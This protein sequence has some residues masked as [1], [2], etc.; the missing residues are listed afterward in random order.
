MRTKR[1]MIEDLGIASRDD[2]DALGTI[3]WPAVAEVTH[4]LYG[5]MA[6]YVAADTSRIEETARLI[7]S[8][9][10]MKEAIVQL[11]RDHDAGEL[12]L[13]PERLAM[14]RGA[15]TGGRA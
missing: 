1:N 3:I 6:G 4:Y 10:A 2:A 12:A 14:L 11:L 8:A 7:K 13:S 15:L 5:E 9:P